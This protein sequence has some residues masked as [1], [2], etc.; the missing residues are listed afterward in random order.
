MMEEF[1]VELYDNKDLLIT[2][3]II[4]E[5]NIS[6]ALEAAKNEAYHL[7]NINVCI[8]YTVS[9][10]NENNHLVYKTL[11]KKTEKYY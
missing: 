1:S 10:S 9:V 4:F 5:E 7:I 6:M 3:Y 8:P 11:T 2:R